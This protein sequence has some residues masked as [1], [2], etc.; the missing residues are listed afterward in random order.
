MK[1]GRT[2]FD[3]GALFDEIFEAARGISDSFKDFPFDRGPFGPW[4]P[5]GVDFY[6]NYSYPPMN[7][8]MTRDRALI[9]EFALAGFE[10]KDISLSFQGDYMCFEAKAPAGSDDGAE[11]GEGRRYLK[12]RLKMKDI[13]RQKYFVPADKFE[14]TAVKAIFR[15]GILRVTVPA[16]EK[17]ETT[18]GVRIN[19]VNEDD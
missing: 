15:N 1:S 4:G 19:I 13:E 12:R 14:Q 3:L 11:S 10:E 18:E 8:S 9:F 2:Q 17:P 5:E 6:P 16:R 7:L